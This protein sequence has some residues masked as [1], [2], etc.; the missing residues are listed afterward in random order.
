MQLEA[1]LNFAQ[2]AGD[3]EPLHASVVQKVARVELVQLA[4]ASLVLPV[5]M[6][7]DRPVFLV[8]SLHFVYVLS[9]IFHA[10]EGL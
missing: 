8:D 7:K 2:E 9:H 1:F 10:Q 3:V 6:I 5:Q 4:V